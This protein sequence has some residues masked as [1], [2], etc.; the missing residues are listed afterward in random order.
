MLVV[1]QSRLEL[2]NPDLLVYL[3]RL[4]R[5]FVALAEAEDETKDPEGSESSAEPVGL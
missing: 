5:T 1:P 3:Q 4:A 2:Q